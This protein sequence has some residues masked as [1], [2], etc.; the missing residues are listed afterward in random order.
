MGGL[1]RKHIVQGCETSLRRLGMETIDLYQIH[2]FDWH[3]PLDEMLSALDLLVRQGKVR[4]LGASSMT[5][6]KFAQR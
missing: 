4:Y 2:R 1:S 6:W 3:T 5:A